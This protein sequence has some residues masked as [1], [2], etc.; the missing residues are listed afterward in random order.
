MENGSHRLCY[1]FWEA[2]GSL[3]EAIDARLGL[4]APPADRW[5]ALYGEHK[6]LL[7]AFGEE[8]L[9]L[10]RFPRV[11]E[12]DRAEEV[13]AKLGSP[14]RAL[15]A[16]VQGGGANEGGWSEVAA[17]F[18]IGVPAR[19]RWEVLCEEHGRFQRK[20]AKVWGYGGGGIRADDT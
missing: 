18:G 15:R 16:F 10:G 6:E 2:G 5:E 3:G 8:A 9:R 14:K 1:V 13:S 7:D 12:F 17:R 20:A 11:E 19:A 4:G